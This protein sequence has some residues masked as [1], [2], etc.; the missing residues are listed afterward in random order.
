MCAHA[1]TRRYGD[2]DN[3]LTGET[4]GR[5]STGEE[6]ALRDAITSANIPTLLMVLTQLT[7]DLH[8]LQPPYVLSRTKGMSDND[9][10]G[11]T[12]DLQR[13]ARAPAAEAIIAWHRGKPVAIR[14]PTPSLLTEMLG[15]S[16]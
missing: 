13:T 16:M 15:V 12:E 5:E 8:W 9:T 10:G 3:V 1:E 6:Q 7:G 14:H 11:L 2:D 4:T